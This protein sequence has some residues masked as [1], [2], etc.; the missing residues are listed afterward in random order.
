MVFSSYLFVASNNLD[1]SCAFSAV[2]DFINEEAIDDAWTVSSYLS[3]ADTL[4]A[5]LSGLFIRN[6]EAS[7]IV[8]SAAASVAARGVLFGNTQP[9]SSRY[10]VALKLFITSV[11]QLIYS[12]SHSGGMLFVD[13]GCGRSR[14]QCGI[15][16]LVVLNILF[17]TL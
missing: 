17:Y 14:N 12:L 5:S 8:Q 2:L 11:V 6:Y 1:I 13:L 3:D 7:N 4:L 10:G 16:R 9:L 15:T